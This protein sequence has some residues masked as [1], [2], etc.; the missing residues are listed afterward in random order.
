MELLPDTPRRSLHVVKLTQT[1]AL[2][3]RLGQAAQP[4]DLILLTGNLGAGK[5]ALT[6]GIARGLGIIATVN[7]PTFTVLKEYH[8]GRLPLYHFDLY[9]LD[10][11]DEIWDLGFGDYFAGDGVSV[12]E[13]AERAAD[14]WTQDYVWLALTATGKHARE[15]TLAAQGERGRDLLLDLESAP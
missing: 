14:A 15:I 2:G 9:R 5:T 7:S 1:Q 12:V 3:E 6:Q 11:P 4:G 10:T 13:W 8:G